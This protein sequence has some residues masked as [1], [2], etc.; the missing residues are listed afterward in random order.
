MKFSMIPLL[1]LAQILAIWL[2][3]RRANRI[4]KITGSGMTLIAM[5]LFLF[6]IWAGA[7]SYLAFSGIYHSNW[8]L[9]SWP[10]F[11]VTF[12]A[13]AIFMVPISVSSGARET[14]RGVIDATPLHWAV[15]F[16]GL[17]ILA[18]GGIM[19]AASGDFSRYFGFY[20][21]IP[22]FIFGL[23]ALLMAWFVY[24]KQVGAKAVIAWNVAGAMII[25][26][27]G[28]VL[29]QMGL[30][31]AWLTFTDVPTILTIFEFPMALAP[32]VVVPV[33]IMM[34]LLISIRLIERLMAKKEG[35]S[36]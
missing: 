21:G 16:Q 1:I 30:P 19:K 13:V 9:S 23:S 25:V 27:V 11:W 5:L 35:M 6:T 8:F 7:S 14:V 10:A 28:M 34:N 3:T 4:G 36:V 24:K 20:I 32:T 18:L 17:R 26:P 22:D 31:G 2:V 15:G 33:F 29:M 12:I